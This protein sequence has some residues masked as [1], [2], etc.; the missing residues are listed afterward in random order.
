MNT[1]NPEPK[2][3]QILYRSTVPES[4]AILHTAT[5]AYN[6]GEHRHIVPLSQMPLHTL[7]HMPATWV[8]RANLRFSYSRISPNH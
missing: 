8:N 4:N 7:G 1:P 2:S 3:K 5:H 6:M